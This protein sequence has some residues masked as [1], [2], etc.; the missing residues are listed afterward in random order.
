VP[1]FENIGGRN[2][3]GTGY[4]TDAPG[5]GMFLRYRIP[6]WISDCGLGVIL[7]RELSS[8]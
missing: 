5:R 6:F 3:R 4:G 7:L 2:Y 8:T 1:D